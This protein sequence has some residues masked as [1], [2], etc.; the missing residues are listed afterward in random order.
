MM[1]ESTIKNDKIQVTDRELEFSISNKDWTPA[2][3]KFELEER[4]L[5]LAEVSRRAGYSPTAAGR[6]L[7]VSWPAVEEVIAEAIG[8]KPSDIWPS[9]YIDGIPKS[10]TP[11]RRRRIIRDE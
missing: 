6:A 8:T 4:G 10:Y 7:R 1:S 2:R 5:S 9:R 11:R 3:I